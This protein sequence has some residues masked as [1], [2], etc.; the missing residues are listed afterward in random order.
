MASVRKNPVS[1]TVLPSSKTNFKQRT[2]SY[3]CLQKSAT[4]SKSHPMQNSSSP[5]NAL[6]H[7]NI[8]CSQ[9]ASPVHSLNFSDVSD[10]SDLLY[11]RRCKP[12][13]SDPTWVTLQIV[14]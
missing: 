7:L 1:F 14:R 4:L 11:T 13:R 8:S 12:T 3:L 10:E 6:Q 9:Y 2:S 5:I